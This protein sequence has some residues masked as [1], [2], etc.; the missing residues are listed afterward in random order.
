M[1]ALPSP[2]GPHVDKVK[3]LGDNQWLKLGSPAADPQWGKARG[4]SWS[5]N[6]PF[7]RG[8]GGMFVFAEGVHA[9]VKPDG[10]Y[11]NDLWLYD[12]NAHRWVCLYPGIDTRTIAGQIEDGQ[13]AVSEDGLLVD[14][15]GQPLPPL[16]IHAYGYLGYDPDRKQLAIYAGQ[17]ENYFTTG[18]GGVFAEAYRLFDAQRKATKRPDLSP[19]FYDAA[20]GTFECFPVAGA[21][22]GTPYGADMLRYVTSRKQF[23]YG[24][25]D[26]LWFLDREKRAWTAAEPKGDPPTGIDQCAAYDP[27]RDRIYHYCRD[28]KTAGDNFVVYDVKANTWTRP[29]PKGTGP[30]SASSYESI[31]NYDEAND[32]LVVIRLYE[33][34]DEPG[35]R[36]GVYVYDPETNTWADLLPL[37]PEVAA[38]IKNGNYGAYDP[39]RNAYYC[40]FAGDSTDDG[41]MWAYRYKAPKQ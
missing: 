2:P 3:A 27:K 13:L 23:Y 18:E 14:K 33:T 7:A 5:S 11:M 29:R 9:F 25:T 12:V 41:T 34:K 38:E 32:K 30:L 6:M 20:G 17:F 35:Q 36:R 39:D 8:L 21:P 15:Q 22:R 28:G 26:G 40:H 4:R 31:Y 24:G 1:A 37:P 10:R 16:L 19:F